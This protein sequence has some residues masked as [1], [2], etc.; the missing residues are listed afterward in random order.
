MSEFFESCETRNAMIV[1][2]LAVLEM[3]RMQAVILVQS[4]LFDDIHLR[5]HRMFDAVF[6][7][8]DAMSK[9]EEQYL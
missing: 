6:A 4:Q 2:L 5:K 9:I 3:V 1:A 7:G 8:P